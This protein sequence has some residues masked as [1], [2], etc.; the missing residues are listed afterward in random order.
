MASIVRRLLLG[1]AAAAG[2]GALVYAFLPKP[3]EVDV[4]GV[5]RGPLMVTVREDGKTRI[6]ERYVVSTPLAGQLQRVE[7]DP[8]DPVTAGETLLATILP[9]HPELLDPRARA[10]AA[11]RESAADAAVNR[12]R[13]NLEAA[14]AEREDAE[15]E[16][17]RVRR[18]HERG[19]A[20][21]DELDEAVRKMRVRQEEHRAA[22]FS[23]EIA[24]FELEQARAA[25]KRFDEDSS[26][27]EQFDIYAPID[28]QVLRVL[29]ESSAVLPAGTPLMEVGDAKNLEL[30]VDVLSTDAVRISPGDTVLVEHWGGDEP[31]KGRVRLVEPAAF[32]KIS[33]LGVEEQRV[34]VIADLTDEAARRSNLGDGFRFEARIVTWEGDDVLQAPTAALFRHKED[35][36]VFVVNGKHA[37]LRVVQLGHRNPDAAEVLG[38]L[39]EDERV[40]IY[41]SDRIKDGV[42][43]VPRSS[44]E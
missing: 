21:E 41:P 25:L 32:T 20:T 22:E 23:L 43:V 3:I 35:W 39:D 24:Q 1:L 28:G 17:E 30:E 4:A 26:D 18:L 7:K 11:A 34:N 44:E 6:K 31:L 12:A 14:L 15:S 40:V 37:H 2:V 29:Q 19:A 16:H 8:G 42:G 36:A 38:G 27:E 10:E 9:N 13:A 33:A 5:S